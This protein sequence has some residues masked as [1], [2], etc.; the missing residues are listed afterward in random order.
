MTVNHLYPVVIPLSDI[1]F[2]K[3]DVEVDSAT[4]ITSDFAILNY[5]SITDFTISVN[6]VSQSVVKSVE[7]TNI[8]PNSQGGFFYTSDTNGNLPNFVTLNTNYTNST[9]HPNFTNNTEDDPKQL[10]RGAMF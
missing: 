1:N 9:F 8:I 4:F 5:G 3:I 10:L 7:E 2:S 6:R